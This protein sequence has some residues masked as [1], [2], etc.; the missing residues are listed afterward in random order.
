M[1]FVQ[2]VCDGSFSFFNFRF[3]FLFHIQ[4]VMVTSG[5][6]PGLDLYSPHKVD[7]GHHDKR[8]GTHDHDAT[9]YPHQPVKLTH[10]HK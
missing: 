6:F 4:F 2:T 1:V 3:L 9:P 5:L 10:G 8:A 7:H